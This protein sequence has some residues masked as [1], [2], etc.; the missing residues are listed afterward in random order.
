MFRRL[1]L[2]CAAVLCA[3]P[4]EKPKTAAPL[5][6]GSPDVQLTLLITGAENGYLLATPDGEGN[7]RG[8][9]AQLLGRWVK[10]EG[11]CAGRLKAGGAAACEDGSTLVLSTG[12]N[13]NGAAI[14]TF[15]HGEPTAELMAHMGY[16]ASA[17]GNH[18]LDFDNET[19]VKNRDASGITYLAA[20]IGVTG[21]QGKKLGLEPYRIYTRRGVK[22]AVVGLSN[23]RAP[24]TVMQGRFQG[25]EILDP[26][27]KLD[28]L[29]PEV[30]KQGISALVVLMDGCLDSMPPLLEKHPTWRVSVVAGRKCGDATWPDHVGTTQL[31]YAG[32]HFFEYAR[33]KLKVDPAQQPGARLREVKAELV[34]VVA[35]GDD[36]EAD[37]V[38]VKLLV[39][40][41]QRLD[42][43]L[44]ENLG[45]T[46]KGLEQTSDLMYRWIATALR[47]Q[48]KTDVAIINRKGVRTNLPSGNVT[49]ESIYNLIPFENSVVRVKVK[50]D[51]LKKLLD[52]PEARAAGAPKKVDPAATYSVATTDYQYFGGD[53]FTF[54]EA[55]PN[56]DFTGVM[57]QTAVIEWTR[58]LG[59]GAEK[60]LEKLL[61]EK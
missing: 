26:E 12:D 5:D 29:L 14:S 49:A 45:Y 38:S 21:E 40:W 33:V 37:A 42:E 56:A 34:P 39:P 32:H 13:A 27:A 8:G 18:E 22:V 58:R 55:D 2:S 50:G 19:F 59:S 30:W 23:R 44:G 41:K 57:W 1:V 11:H 52:N 20:N 16:A 47:E 10:N 54:A 25:L 48:L 17:F 35:G 51:Q 4:A 24:T 7:M 31:I 60:P 9:A 53:A 61:A 15:F 46:D 3:C 43:Q 36:A 28:E 6:A